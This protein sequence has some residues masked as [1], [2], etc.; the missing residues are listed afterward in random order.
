MHRFG[1][2]GGRP[3]AYLHAAL[4]AQELPGIVVLDHLIGRLSETDAA[5]R[6]TGEIVVVPFANPVGLA[7]QVMMEALGR[8]DL[9]TNRNY[10]RGFPDI[11]DGVVT[12]VDGR[13]GNDRDANV[14]MV[15]AAAAAVLDRRRD[16]REDDVLKV[17]LFRL[18]C[19]CD[20]VLDLHTAWEALPHMLVT[21]GNWPDASD[22]ACEMASEVV[23]VDRGNPLMTFK[24]AHVLVWQGI[25]ERF[26]G[27][28]LAPGCLPVVLEL[29]G[30]RD[31]DDH[32]TEPAATGLFRW[33]QRRGVIE[34]SP[35]VLPEP[36]CKARS[37]SGL[38]RLL[39]ARGG[40]VIY[41]KHLGENVGAGETFAEIL[42]PESGGREPVTSPVHGLLH[43]RRSHRLVRKGQ[44]FCA[45]AG[46]VPHAP[47]ES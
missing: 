1:Q 27:M 40:I 6:V 9:D 13:L 7:Q 31:V 8:H 4:H 12:H 42:D 16:L 17:T 24:S 18:S 25:A 38:K 34:G 33:L 29:R 21:D 47:S 15:R 45:I 19:D 43:A 32:F 46:D 37:V 2:P 23:I 41:L 28:P 3:K 10:N 39:A 11:L 14:S 36:R 44:Y 22:L 20:F 35:G 5:G 26:P 30:Q